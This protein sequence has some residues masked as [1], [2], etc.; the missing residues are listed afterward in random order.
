[1]MKKTIALVMLILVIALTGC[2]S[3]ETE[4]EVVPPED[5]LRITFVT[6]L[7]NHPIWDAAREGFEQAAI[8]LN[9][10]PE[11]VGAQ[12]IAPDE[13]SGLI[14]KAI[15]SKVDGIITMPIAPEAMR[16][17]IKDCADA[18]IPVVFVGAE[19]DLSES[20][21][22]VGTNEAQLGKTGAEK[23][24]EKFGGEPIKAVIMQSTMDASFA[25][26]ARD[27]YLEALKDYP[28]FEMVVNVD[29]NSDMVQAMRV[30]ERV[31]TEY[32]EINTVIGVCGEAG[33]AAAKVAENM[34]IEDRLTI[35]AV[36]DI[37][38]IKEMIQK[39]KIWGTLAQNFYQMGYK[40]AEIMCAY[41]R[42]GEVPEN[43]NDT[44]SIFVD[45]SNME[46]YLDELRSD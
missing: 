38:E 11:Y 22:F 15:S 27:G 31:F 26:K 25:I 9:F 24:M 2:I 16:A 39:G 33:P 34:G 35:I 41:L 18:N 6:P 13:M 8:D 10:G 46:T 3:V 20:L 28:D 43:Y 4:T 45:N 7:Y 14:D 42:D 36:D 29:C 40:S 37:D 30:Y 23:L 1:M 19:D 44:G 5:G 32:P 21:A 12:Y 17:A